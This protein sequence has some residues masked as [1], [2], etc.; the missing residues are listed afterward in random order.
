[1]PPSILRAG[2]LLALVMHLAMPTAN[3]AEPPIRW[4]VQDAPPLLS[5]VDGQPPR[6]AQDLKN[7]EV[8]GF[9]RLLIAEL[10]E[11]RHEFF[12]ATLPRFELMVKSGETVCSLLHKRSPER[13]KDRY[14]T[15]TLPWLT[16]NQLYLVVRRDQLEKFA[17]LGRPVALAELL[18]RQDLSGLLTRDRSY[19]RQ[20]DTL[21]QGPHQGAIKTLSVRKGS[22]LLIMLRAKRMDY[23]LETQAEVKEF[24]GAGEADLLMLPL[25][26]GPTESLRYVSCSRTPAGRMQI[27]A[28]DRAIR[29]LAGDPQREVWLRNWLGS[30]LDVQER[31][32]LLRYLDE[33]ARSGPQIE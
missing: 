8:D 22:Q 9:L 15:S 19:G 27:E 21:L 3:A 10:P 31:R 16:S 18:R 29:K 2:P 25:K 13:L 6:Q 5:F 1:M 30:S 24:L 7:G 14:F 33:R 32:R 11:F 20:I 12:D 23:V 17:G 28:I 4:F 26:E